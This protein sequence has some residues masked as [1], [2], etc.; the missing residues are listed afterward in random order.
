MKPVLEDLYGWKDKDSND[1]KQ[2]MIE[3]YIKNIVNL[4]LG[5]TAPSRTS[6]IWGWA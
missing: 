4:G 3:G 2:K 1:K 6:S 5:M